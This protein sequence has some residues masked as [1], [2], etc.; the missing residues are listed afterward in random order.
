MGNDAGDTVVASGANFISGTLEP[1]LTHVLGIIEGREYD[2]IV[3]CFSNAEMYT[4]L[5]TDNPGKLKTYMNQKIAGAGALLQ[6]AVMGATGALAS[7]K[8]GIGVLDHT[9]S[10]CV[11]CMNGESLPS[12]WAGAEAGAAPPRGH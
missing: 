12:E 3:P 11:Y 10:E 6:Q 5:S 7:I 4:C 2:V 8:T 9:L 1:T